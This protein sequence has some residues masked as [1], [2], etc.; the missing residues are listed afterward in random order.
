MIFRTAIFALV[1][2]AF[3]STAWSNAVVQDQFGANFP[4][5]VPWVVSPA[6]GNP[7]FRGQCESSK[8]DYFCAFQRLKFGSGL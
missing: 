4:V 6:F 5:S 3:V 7:E 8:N 1:S 2:T